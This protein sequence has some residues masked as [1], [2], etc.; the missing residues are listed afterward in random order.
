MIFSVQVSARTE[1]GR[2][3]TGRT[4]G[5]KTDDDDGTEGRTED[6][7]GGNGTDTTGPTDDMYIVPKFQIRLWDQDYNVKVG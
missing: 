5:Q 7:D 3:T 1:R 2:T 6:D 4:D